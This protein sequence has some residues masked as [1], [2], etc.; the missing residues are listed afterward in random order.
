MEVDGAV[1][2]VTG[3]SSGIGAATARALGSLGATV[4]LA[5]RRTRRLATVAADVPGAVAVTCDVTAPGGLEAL[6]S[7]VLDRFG[8]VDVLVNDAGQGLHV[9]VAEIGPDDLRAVLEL[10]VLAP[11]RGMQAVL[12]PM[13][14]RGAG[15]IVNVSSATA[16]R[17]FPGLGG[18]SATKAAL[19]LLSEVA[20]L[21]WAD[22]H[23]AVSTVYPSVTATEFHQHLRAGSIPAGAAAITPDPPELAARAVVHAVV[24]GDPHVLVADPPRS[25]SPWDGA[26]PWGGGRGRTG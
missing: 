20:R 5:A 24:T 1:C 7:G 11:L 6:V 16:L 15:S 25:I 8:R 3:A 12:A 26:A 14:G 4:V 22:L 21:E 9:P 23:I 10:N 17:P 19:D 18:Y 2:I 13:R